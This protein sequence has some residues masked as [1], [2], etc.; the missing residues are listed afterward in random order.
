MHI[1]HKFYFS[2]FLY[3]CL[4]VYSCRP[5]LLMTHNIYIYRW[6]LKTRPYPHCFSEIVQCLPCFFSFAPHLQMIYP[7]ATHTKHSYLLLSPP[8]P[9]TFHAHLILFI[10]FKFSFACV[11]N[12]FC[13]GLQFLLPCGFQGKDFLA[14][15]L[16]D[17]LNVCPIQRWCHFLNS[18]CHGV[19]S[20][21]HACPTGDYVIMVLVALCKYNIHNIL[22]NWI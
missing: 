11:A 4:L 18:W 6:S 8:P 22:K 16:T 9:P 14:V 10:C 15:P 3:N 12:T 2:I 5:F 19:H 21:L 17:F 7:E 13:T 1:L 20:S